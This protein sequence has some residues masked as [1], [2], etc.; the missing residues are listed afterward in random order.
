VLASFELRPDCWT[1]EILFD[2]RGVFVSFA[3]IVFCADTS[4]LGSASLGDVGDG[5][6]GGGFGGRHRNSDFET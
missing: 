1:V 3:T 6:N 2:G 5:S 4:A